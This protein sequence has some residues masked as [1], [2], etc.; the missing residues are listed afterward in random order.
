[1]T[2]TASYGYAYGLTY[3]T[4]KRRNLDRQVIVATVEL[5]RFTFIVVVLSLA[6]SV[7]AA[8]VVA[9]LLSALSLSAASLIVPV[10]GVAAGLF[11]VDQRSRRGLGLRRYASM[12]D[13]HRG[14]AVNSTVFVCSEPVHDT[15]LHILVPSV[16]R[17]EAYDPTDLDDADD[18]FASA[19]HGHRAVAPGIG[20]ADPHA[21]DSLKVTYIE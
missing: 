20:R 4:G 19:D 10:I 7:P 16:I 3:L 11:L 15:Q 6:A 17:N 8:L 13:R 1:M 18:L 9:A 14:R 2:E 21:D 5:N 12:W